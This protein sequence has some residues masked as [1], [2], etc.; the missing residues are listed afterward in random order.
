MREFLNDSAFGKS[1]PLKIVLIF[2][3]NTDNPYLLR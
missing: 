1:M 2:S 3:I